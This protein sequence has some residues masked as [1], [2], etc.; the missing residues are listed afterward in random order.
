MMS[1]FDCITA[2]VMALIT[3]YQKHAFDPHNPADVKTMERWHRSLSS[4]PSDIEAI[5][6]AFEPLYSHGNMP[7]PSDFL[8]QYTHIS[9]SRDGSVLA[10]LDGGAKQ[11]TMRDME[12]AATTQYGKAVLHLMKRFMGIR[13]AKT[14]RDGRVLEWVDKSE[15][16]IG[17]TKE[18]MRELYRISR[19]HGVPWE[20]EVPS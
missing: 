5:D 2:H 8:A 3:Q 13:K 10:V 11:I 16:D 6:R 7:Q 20:G 19:E 15:C 12:G 1:K 9:S 17:S 18:Y 14:T 4:V